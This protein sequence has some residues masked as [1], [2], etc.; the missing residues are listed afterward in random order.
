MRRLVSALLFSILLTDPARACLNTYGKNINGADVEEEHAAYLVDFKGITSHPEHDAIKAKDLGPEPAVDADFKIRNDY[1]AN[2]VRQG[3]TQKAIEILESVEKSHPGEYMVAANL[4]TAY[5][6]N[7]EVDKAMTWI[8][9]GIKRNPQA[10]GGT[11][12]LHL[13]ILEAKK[14]LAKDPTWLQSHTVL[15]FDFGK[16]VEP[17]P[18]AVWGEMG[19]TRVLAAL[20]YQLHERL[21][22][23]TPPDP[24]VAELLGFC[25]DVV[26]VSEPA[27][28]SIP[29]YDLA[30]QFK[31]VHADL[32]EKRRLMAVSIRL[33]SPDEW[34]ASEWL[35][36]TGAIL[37]GLLIAFKIWRY[38]G[39]GSP[40][41]GRRPA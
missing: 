19:Q 27:R 28:N 23:V 39:L 34:T 21:A 14:N 22:F 15:G 36:G 33:T 12:W 7:G 2:I 35:V 20:G 6:L 29:Y 17:I 13:R 30:L 26:A 24:I 25:A 1:A 11:E 41:S 8:A 40:D 37:V 18:P 31:P 38:L 32:M 4:G 10:H 5:E 9:E 3:R 16:N